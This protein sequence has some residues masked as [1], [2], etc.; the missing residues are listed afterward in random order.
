VLPPI[1]QIKTYDSFIGDTNKIKKVKTNEEEDLCGRCKQK[2]S[3]DYD[4]NEEGFDLET[5]GIEIFD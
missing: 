4:F 2:S 1:R 3:P 5:L